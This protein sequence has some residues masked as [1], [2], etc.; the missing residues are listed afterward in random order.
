MRGMVILIGENHYDRAIH[1]RVKTIM[2]GFDSHRGDR[3]FLE[4]SEDEQ[5]EER[6]A[7]YGMAP[8]DCRLLEKNSQALAEISSLKFE[9]EQA[10]EDYLSFLVE[11]VPSAW[12]GLDGFVFTPEACND[13]VRKYAPELPASHRATF[14]AMG[15]RFDALQD[16]M[17]SE[18]VR[19]TPARDAHMAN[20]VRNDRT[21][22]GLNYLIV[23]ADHLAGIGERLKDLPVMRVLPRK[24]AASFP[25]LK[26]EL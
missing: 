22:Q 19:S 26:E 8:K 5:C 7:A 10:M 14:N 3:F 9:L 12:E 11:H 6:V 1:D 17:E 4:N 23:G 20:V 16:R 24:L 2:H 18:T 25:H 21:V 15:R 13:F